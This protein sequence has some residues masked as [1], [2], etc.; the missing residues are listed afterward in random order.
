MVQYRWTDIDQWKDHGVIKDIWI[1]TLVFKY[2]L[3]LSFPINIARKI[4]FA[5]NFRNPPDLRATDNLLKQL[6]RPLTTL[7]Q[8]VPLWTFIFAEMIRF[9]MQKIIC[10]FVLLCT[11]QKGI[12]RGRTRKTANAVLHW[13]VFCYYSSIIPLCTDIFLLNDF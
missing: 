11:Q 4:G 12:E 7:P 13:L 6:I 3:N 9:S 10:L 1:F 2:K 5:C 8:P